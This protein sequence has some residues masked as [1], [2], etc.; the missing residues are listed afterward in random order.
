MVKNKGKGGKGHRKAKSGDGEL[1]RRQLILK[2]DGQE[3]ARVSKMLG[4]G[5][6]ECACYDNVI[7]LGHIRGKM[8][9]RVW[10]GMNDLVLCG[11]RD[12]QDGKADIIHKYTNDEIMNLMNIG[13]IPKEEDAETP[14]AQQT[15]LSSIVLNISESSQ[16]IEDD[17][18]INFDS[19]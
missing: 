16:T 18:T 11:L 12:Y 3:Y 9:R 19:I 7:R 17:S 8:R 1:F 4:N 10:V 5:H 13:E 6:V 14:Q 2:E 15:D